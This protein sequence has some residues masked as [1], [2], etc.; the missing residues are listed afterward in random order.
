MIFLYQACGF[1]HPYSC[2]P[3]C[4]PIVAHVPTS[5]H[6]VGTVPLC[7][8]C[9]ARLESIAAEAG[10]SVECVRLERRGAA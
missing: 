9:L 7:A 5:N 1:S 6:V 8:E 10:R 2:R 4:G 3:K